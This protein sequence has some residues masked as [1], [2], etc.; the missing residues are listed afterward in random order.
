[1][2]EAEKRHIPNIGKPYVPELL[3]P[4]LSGSEV[5][6]P[7]GTTT[8]AVRFKKSEPGTYS[9]AGLPIKFNV[10]D[11]TLPEATELPVQNTMYIMASG[12]DTQNIHPEFREYG[13]S[14]M[15]TSP[16]AAPIPLKIV[17]VKLVA[18]FSKFDA[19]LKIKNIALVFDK[20]SFSNFDIL[21]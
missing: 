2:K 11:I 8:F 3:T 12:T 6:L 5:E 20:I 18:D 1:M 9:I 13:I 21:L 15:L 7:A 19:R 10:L 14:T 4:L 17:D 16:W